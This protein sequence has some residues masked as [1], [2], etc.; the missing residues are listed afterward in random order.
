MELNTIKSNNDLDK[1]KYL[2]YEWFNK[3]ESDF[4]K[5]LHCMIK[6]IDLPVTE[7]EKYI[8]GLIKKSYKF[9]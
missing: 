3:N 9:V 6:K 1:L 4:D 2:Y 8:Y 7:K 5:M